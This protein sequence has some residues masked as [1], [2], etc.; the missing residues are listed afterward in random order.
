[1]SKHD[2]I[3]LTTYVLYLRVST[4]GQGR[5]GLGLSAQR[6]IA[7]RMVQAEGSSIVAEFVEVES[8]RKSDRPQLRAALALAKKEGAC[9]LVA[10][11][12]RLARSVGFVARLIESGA[13]FK[14]A[15]APFADKT[16]VQMLSVMS[17]WE[18]DQISKRTTDALAQAKANGTRLGNPHP[19]T[20]V[21]H[22]DKWN[23]TQQEAAEKH[24]QTVAHLVNRLNSEGRTLQE[25]ADELTGGGYRTARGGRWFPSTVRNVLIR[26]SAA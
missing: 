6:E 19:E 16:M 10:K 14:A 26:L 22:R 17:E 11:L 23:A 21:A 18:A 25:I 24:A 4:K 1:M 2:G 3:L 15:D 13:S 12:D 8:G 9:L 5:S 7:S 20:L